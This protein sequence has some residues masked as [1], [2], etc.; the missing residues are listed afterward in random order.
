MA[1]FDSVSTARVIE[2]DLARAQGH[3]NDAIDIL[4]TSMRNTPHRQA[5]IDALIAANWDILP[6]RTAAIEQVRDADN[7]ARHVEPIPETLQLRAARYNYAIEHRSNGWRFIATHRENGAVAH[8]SVNFFPT[9]EQAKA[10]AVDHMLG[11]LI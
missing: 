1:T 2:S 9:P 3:I 11:N 7:A 6:I 5:V 4:R 10:D 8:L